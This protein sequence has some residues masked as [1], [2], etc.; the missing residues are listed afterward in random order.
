MTVTL[1]TFTPKGAR[2]DFT[3]SGKPMIIGRK[4]EADIRIPLDE[5]S[6]AHAEI[7]MNGTKV[8]AKDLGSRNG[9]F[10]NEQKIAQATLKAGDQLRVGSVVFFVQIDGVPREFKPLTPMGGGKSATASTVTKTAAPTPSKTTEPSDDD[11]DIDSLEELGSPDLS[12]FDIEEIAD[13]DSS[14]DIE[15]IAEVEELDEDDLLE[16][17]DTPPPKKK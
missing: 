13:D 11:F 10:V 7:T 17:D 9:T 12:D 15:E 16:D 6:R 1:V 3:L 14:E 5:I 4:P 8:I 2:K